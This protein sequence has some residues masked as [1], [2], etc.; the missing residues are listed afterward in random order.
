[1]NNIRHDN[2]EPFL[3]EICEYKNRHDP[4]KLA[5][6]KYYHN[7]KQNKISCEECRTGWITH[8]SRMLGNRIFDTLSK[9]LINQREYLVE[10]SYPEVVDNEFTAQ[11]I[12]TEDFV[13]PYTG[14]TF[15]TFKEHCEYDIKDVS[16]S[17]GNI[18]PNIYISVYVFD[19]VV[20]STDWDYKINLHIDCLDNNS[21]DLD[22]I[23]IKLE[24]GLSVCF[25]INNKELSDVAIHSIMRMK[26]NYKYSSDDDYYNE[27]PWEK[28]NICKV[29]TNSYYIYSNSIYC[30]DCMYAKVVDLAM[31][32][33]VQ[34][35]V[36]LSTDYIS[37][38][39]PIRDTP[40]WKRSVIDK[41][42]NIMKKSGFDPR[43]RHTKATVQK[44]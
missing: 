28:C 12:F 39:Y 17:D 25:D 44:L 20:Y 37:T 4:S 24:H 29:T 16:S 13:H 21:L 34:D 30:L 22:R 23:V 26:G 27:F 36:G 11:H 42:C 2:A 41:Y 7:H 5:T 38:V 9:L 10:L 32:N 3:Y 6:K 18:L 43:I 33:H 40:E 14:N 19:I 31:K 8:Y 1:M 15:I 35:E